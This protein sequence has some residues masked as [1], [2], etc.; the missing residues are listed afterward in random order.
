[1]P[2]KVP[3][4]R[5]LVR[6]CSFL[7]ASLA[8]AACS[9]SSR[10]PTQTETAALVA[11]RISNLSYASGT[12]PVTAYD[13]IIPATADPTWETT[14]CTATPAVGLN[15]NWQN[16]HAAV[17][18]LTHPWLND[19][20]TG[21][22]WI[23]A[24]G[25]PGQT[26]PSMG[27]AGQSWTKYTTQVQGNGTFVI[28]LMAD[29][30][31]W[32]YLDNT[33]VGVQG[34]DR[35]K[36][37]YGITLNGTH[38]LSFIIFDGGGAAGGKFILET[39]T[40]PPPPL[41]SD[42][43]GVPNLTDP[44]PYTSNFYYYVDWTAADAGAGTASGTISL[45]GG[46]TVGVSLRVRNPNGSAGS[47][48]SSQL[49]CGTAFWTA[50]SSAP[51][52]SA[53]VLNGPPACDIIQLQGG[54]SSTYEITFS[55][56]VSDP[57][58]PV[59]SLGSG[60]NPTYYDF[61]RQFQVVSTGPGYFGNG[62]FRAD[63]GEVLY[64]AE[65][66]GT[67]RFIGSIATL[68]WTVPHAEWWH[69]FT[70]GI[71]GKASAN[72]TSDF[73]LDGVFD[74]TDNCPQTANANQADADADGVGDACDAVDDNTA[75]PDGDTLTNA[76]EHV[77]G[78][79]P[80]NPDTDGDG[81]KDNVDPFP[82]DPT[83]SKLASTTTV[84]FGS[85]PF[86]Y[87][88]SA[89]TATA[90]VSPGGT[91]TIAYS[92]DCTNAGTTCTAT[93]TYAGDATHS[94]SSATAT[95]TITKVPSTT[96]VSFGNGPFQYTGA[97]FAATAS[98][99]PNG[100]AS[101]VYS[102]DCTNAGTSCVATATY[103]GDANHTGS[104]ATASITITKAPSTTTVSFGSGPF[105]YTG[106]AYTATASVSPSGTASIAYTG[107]CINGGSTCTATA[108]YGGDPNHFGSQA[109]ANI[110]ITYTVCAVRNDD[111][112]DDDDDHGDK[113]SRGVEAGSTIPVKLRVCNAAGR[114]I[115]SR[116]LPVKAIGVSPTG[117]LNDSGRSNPGNL[118]RLDDGTYMFN[119]STK[120]FTAGSYTLDYRIGND[121]TVYQYAFTVRAKTSEGKDEKSDDKKGGKKS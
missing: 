87:R 54:S 90:S 13:A 20:F 42:G 64:G 93:A 9:D 97:P 50:N 119:L 59:L 58:M 37:S 117:S 83:R 25:T 78:T 88:G 98:V 74:A 68:S 79:D 104:N 86:P 6:C 51:Y 77:L 94:G 29:N 62:P 45:P 35:F 24:W 17:T 84:S 118:F 53:S 121:P 14:K 89:Y 115:S 12:T 61:D 21:A 33:L 110:T 96:T 27:P 30:C 80:L 101:I 114:N 1:M 4:T 40:T 76:Q 7:I 47:F 109:T 32:I 66:H 75:D 26:P 52:I 2:P 46:Q 55:E 43:D 39:T 70:F 113:A 65:G 18:G 100:I 19:S 49:G 116:A 103:A 5:W 60:P 108:T 82:L 107:D 92:G 57:I 34:T 63:P 10:T 73:D 69:G 11:G 95:I 41:D 16:P 71:R 23:N 112:D 120:G 22:G 3:A 111:D 8:L 106:L 44:E 28:R 99:S 15:A 67:I 38:N 36:N 56:P 31:S 81:A 105:P 85:G 48:Y 102:G 91:A 72:P